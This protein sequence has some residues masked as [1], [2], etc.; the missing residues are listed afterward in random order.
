VDRGENKYGASAR[1]GAAVPSQCDPPHGI[2]QHGAGNRA[3][4]GCDART[5][6]PGLSARAPLNVRISDD[7]HPDMSTD[8]SNISTRQPFAMGS[9]TH[10]PID[11]AA[12]LARM[13]RHRVLVCCKR[14]FVSPSVDTADG[15]YS[16]D[17]P[18]IRILQRIEY[19]YTD[20]GVNFTGIQIILALVD[21]VERFR[22][23]R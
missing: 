7:V 3:S 11:L 1:I 22:E 18:S 6:N 8:T 4:I 20:C 10:Y 16:F 19:L 13:P 17:A 14:G 21:E 9:E 2:V 5:G 23:E 15:R 12:R